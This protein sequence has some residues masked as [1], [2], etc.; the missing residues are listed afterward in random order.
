MSVSEN[1]KKIRERFDL[2]Q[3][4]LAEIA[5]VS[6]K[7]VSTWEVGTK[8]PR[9]GAVERI[10]NALN[11]KK[12][13]IIDDGGMD[14]L[15]TEEEMILHKFRLLD[16]RGRHT[17]KTILEM[18]YNRIRDNQFEVVAAHSDDYSPDEVKRINKDLDNLDKM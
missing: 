11:L 13:N 3:Q 10:A 5:G 14:K 6:N 4:E 1:I 7:A 15:P 8:E 9:M 18:E 12:S 2:T 17:V 16:S